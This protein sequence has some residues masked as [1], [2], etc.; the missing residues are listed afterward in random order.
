MKNKNKLIKMNIL[1]MN[2]CHVCTVHHNA[3]RTPRPTSATCENRK[4][5][6][7]LFVFAWRKWLFHK[8]RRL[9]IRPYVTRNFAGIRE[10]QTTRQKVVLG[11]LILNSRNSKTTTRRHP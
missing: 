8:P 4:N 10:L 6:P 3:K 9:L 2:G 7:M 11:I 5:K 1:N